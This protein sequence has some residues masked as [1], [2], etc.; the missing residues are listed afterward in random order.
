MPEKNL[1][2]L[3]NQLREEIAQLPES[4]HSARERLTMLVTDLEARLEA[5]DPQD[6]DTLVQNVRESIRHLEVEHPRTTGVLNHIMMTLS[7]MGI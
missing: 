4:D 1:Q 7:N 3:I 6:H 5:P 2:Q